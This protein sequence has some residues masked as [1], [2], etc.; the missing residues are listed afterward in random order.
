MVVITEQRH[1]TGIEWTHFPG[2]I[3]ATWNPLA[4]CSKCAPGCKN[5]YAIRE[6]HRLAGNP[7]PKIAARYKGLTVI[8]NGK[9][10]WTGVVRLVPEVLDKPL[11]TRKPHSYFISLSDLFHEDLPDEAIDKVFALAALTPR[12]RYVF[13]TK[14]GRRLREWSVSFHGTQGCPSSIEF[15]KR[16]GTDFKLPLP[17][18]ILGV[19]ASTQRDVDEQVPELLRTPAACRMLS[20][21]PQI[22]DVDVRPYLHECADC[23]GL[24]P[25]EMPR[26]FRCTWCAGTGRGL[27][28]VVQGG[29][30]GHDARPFDIQW[31]RKTKQQCADAGMA[32]F[33]KQLGAD[34]WESGDGDHGPNAGNRLLLE[35][36]K[37]GDESEWPSDLQGCR[38][39]PQIGAADAQ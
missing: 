21:E 15:R 37:G 39:F 10:N 16:N 17:N 4:G 26:G 28:W 11:R 27:G 30:S 22:E 31:A 33:L 7:N 18:V 23:S 24:P 12:H 19:S 9:P 29:E 13:L 8:E 34:P 32:Y 35:D 3:G 14:R 25:A 2:Y 20:L 38:A 6:A 5:C 36:R 1:E